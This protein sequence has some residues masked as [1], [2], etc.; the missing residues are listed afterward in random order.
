MRLFKLTVALTLPMFGLCAGQLDSRLKR[1][2][3]AWA[4]NPNAILASLNSQTK[5]GKEHMPPLSKKGNKVTVSTTLALYST[6]SLDRLK[7]EYTRVAPNLVTA[8]VPLSDLK[9]LERD[10]SIQRINMARPMGMHNE[11]NMQKLN[12]ATAYGAG[13]TGCE[14]LVGI[15]DTGIDPA[16]PAFKVDG[17][18]S[19]ASRIQYLWDQTEAT[20]Q[21]FS[22]GTFSS[23]KGQRW[24]EAEITAGYCTSKD[25]DGH[26]THV[27]GSAAGFDATYPLRHGAARDANIL[28]VKSTLSSADVLNGVAWLNEQAKAMGK[29]IVINMSLGSQWGPHDGTDMETQAVDELIADSNGNLLVVRSAGNAATDGLHDSATLS[30]EIAAIPFAVG[31]Y[32]PESDEWDGLGACFYYDATSNLSLRIKDSTGNYSPWFS[33][34][35]TTHVGTLSDGS[36][37]EIIHRPLPESNNPAIKLIDIWIGDDPYDAQAYIR[38]GNWSLEFKTDTGTPRLDGWIWYSLDYRIF[39]TAPDTDITLGNEACGKNIIS[40]AAYVSRYQWLAIDNGTYNFGIGYAQDVIAPFSSRGPTRDSRPKPDITAGGTLIL[41]T[42]SANAAAPNDAFLPP[43]GSS[44]YVY[45]QGT[46]MSAPTVAGAVALLKEAHPSWTYADV[47][48]YFQTHSQGTTIH[49]GFGAWDKAWGWGV[50]DLTALLSQV[51][52][53]LFITTQPLS[54]TVMV[55][56]PCRLSFSSAGGTPPYRYQWEKDG[57][58]IPGA[59]LNTLSFESTQTEDSGAYTCTVTDASDYKATSSAATLAVK[60]MKSRDLND[61]T[62]VDVRD[63]AWL[64]RALGK[65]SLNPHWEDD[66]IADLNWD[67]RVDDADIALFMEGL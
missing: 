61:D 18:A 45:M 41:S 54:Q 46:S 5:P 12:V 33:P 22:V 48:Q 11:I 42:R 13:Y 14:V 20:H 56:R 23:N 10:F 53:S 51:A 29:P 35:N 55:G 3:R 25:T 7:I 32:T 26:G 30:A 37:F 36:G 19:G 49:T 21:P 60:A 17:M 64:T 47:I 57:I 15:I 65:S 44:Q 39:F 16:H 9:A 66:Q 28:I 24:T 4:K 59:I 40:V 67:N 2:Q 8:D 1:L 58:E 52:P 43:T 34:S 31:E 27:A 6:D 62:L 50:L 38:S 63:M